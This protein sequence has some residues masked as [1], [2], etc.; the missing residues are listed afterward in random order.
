MAFELKCQSIAG[1]IAGLVDSDEPCV[2]LGQP[3]ENAGEVD[4]HGAGK[5]SFWGSERKAM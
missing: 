1:A 5:C 2:G 4:S 3:A